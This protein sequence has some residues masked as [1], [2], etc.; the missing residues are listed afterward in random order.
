M[1]RSLLILAL[2]STSALGSAQVISR[3]YD[4]DTHDNFKLQNYETVS[5]IKG[6]VV[7]QITKFTFD[8]PA[9]KLTEAS[10]WFSLPAPTVLSGF[11]YWY[12]DE[13]VKGILMDKNKAWFIYT[14]ITS[15]NE[16]PGIMVQKT[17]QSYH[18]QI[19]P[20]AVGY[21]LRAQLT[22][23]GFVQSDLDTNYLLQPDVSQIAPNTI[24]FNHVVKNPGG[25]VVQKVLKDGQERM[26][27]GESAHASFAVD[28]LAEKYSDGYVYVAGMIKSDKPNVSHW[29]SGLT[30][31]FW[32]RPEAGLGDGSVKLFMGRKKGNASF[33]VY[34]QEKGSGTREMRVCKTTTIEKDTDTAKLWA[35]Q[36]LVQSDWRHNKDVLDFS[37]KYQIPSAQTALL[38]VP[39]EQLKLFKEKAAEYE[40]K[41]KEAERKQREWQK[42]RQMNWNRS[43]GGDPEIRVEFKDAVKVTAYLPDN[44]SFELTKVTNDVWGGNFD[45]PANAA[46]GEYTVRLVAV[47]KNGKTEEKSINY[48]V[49]RTAPKGTLTVENG[50]LVLV[51]TEPLGKAVVLF[52]D[53][54]EEEMTAVADNRYEALLNGRRVVKVVLIDQAHNLGEVEWSH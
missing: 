48:H 11:A 32:T 41:Q 6:P 21:D 52:G 10:L 45:I 20:L 39:Q 25:A 30:D 46:D 37:M 36:R 22:T 51:S 42:Q 53:G 18:C 40:R 47:L 2:A 3:I 31:V 35:H 34:R 44:S 38:A 14:A 28:Y 5:V 43:A 15:R 17:P 13:Y 1:N 9:K 8:N 16:D 26:Q 12:K 50:A 33:T 24:P 54:T 19:F 29:I 4:R 7:K 49:D 23:V 27:V